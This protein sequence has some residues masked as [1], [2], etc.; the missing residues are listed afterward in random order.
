MARRSYR[1]VAFAS[2]L[3]PRSCDA[4][5]ARSS[6]PT[7]RRKH[8]VAWNGR[9]PGDLDQW[10]IPSR[11]QSNNQADE[12]NTLQFKVAAEQHDLALLQS[13]LKQAGSDYGAPR[14]HRNTGSWRSSKV[15][16]SNEVVSLRIQLGGWGGRQPPSPQN[17]NHVE[18]PALSPPEVYSWGNICVR[19]SVWRHPWSEERDHSLAF[20]SGAITL[21]ERASHR[22]PKQEDNRNEQFSALD[23]LL[24]HGQVVRPVESPRG[25][26]HNLNG[27][28][29]VL[30]ARVAVGG[31]KQ[32][33]TFSDSVG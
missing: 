1:P 32:Y 23:L 11:A 12:R 6:S 30:R 18:A 14:D 19:S 28:N 2:D 15:R 27:T 33:Q 24:K 3:P 25:S 4:N 29:R 22:P 21:H 13:L 20:R 17:L 10:G 8:R 9:S 26:V 16:T 7:S 5:Q 31:A